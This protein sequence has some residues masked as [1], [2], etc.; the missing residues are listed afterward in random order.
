M[1]RVI[2]PLVEVSLP[3][4]DHLHHM[5]V[6]PALL[7]VALVGFACICPGAVA[8]HHLM[9]VEAA[10]LVLLV[11]DK[12]PAVPAVQ[13]GIVVDEEIQM[14]FVGSIFLA[15]VAVGVLHLNAPGPVVLVNTR[16]G[17][18]LGVLNAHAVAAKSDM[19]HLVVTCLFLCFRRIGVRFAFCSLQ[20][21]S[22]RNICQIFAFA[23]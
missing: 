23:Y 20:S 13:I 22:K 3:D 11:N 5:I 14:V 8:V 6:P 1:V 2:Q 17:A 12:H 19:S 10:V 9:L 21:V 15:D 18:A 4:A 7:I 16:T